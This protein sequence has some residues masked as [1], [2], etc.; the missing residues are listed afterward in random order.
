MGRPEP[1]AFLV[2]PTAAGKSAVAE[3]LAER[4]GCRIL[5]ADSMQVYRG[6]DIGTA[7]PAA[8]VLSRV[9]YDGLDLADPDAPFS[10]WAYRTAA[11]EALRQAAEAGER[12]IVAGGSGLYV[13]SLTHG[14]DRLPGPS[15]E[16]RGRWQ[17]ELAAGG[18][19]A[20]QER[21]RRLSPA[22]LAALDDPANPRR[23]VRALEL[24]EAGAAPP[25]RRRAAE[26]GGMLVGLEVPPAELNSRIERRVRE[27]YGAGLL[28]EVRA[29]RERWGCLSPTAAQ[30]IGYAEALQ[31]LDGRC[32]VEEAM[33]RTV[34]RTRQLAK[35]QRTWFRHQ[36]RVTWIDAGGGAGLETV[37]AR[38]WEA[39]AR[40]GW[41]DIAE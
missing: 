2:G 12:V 30:A 3:W 15:G 10:V 20:L 38:V 5:S 33:A 28:D 23:L 11:L 27:M 29:L 1:A 32:R 35:R 22:W 40:H 41:T 7:K 37:A 16:S 31:V 9:R 17:A 26:G 21:L 36:A 34:V 14:L 18:V 6:M 8:G 39:W 19:A 24:A 4:H 25:E 13:R